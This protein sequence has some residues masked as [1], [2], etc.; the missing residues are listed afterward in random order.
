MNCFLGGLKVLYF[1]KEFKVVKS[2]FINIGGNGIEI[3]GVK[4]SVIFE[5]IIFVN[6]ENG[7]M[8]IDIDVKNFE[9]FFDG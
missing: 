6:N 4:S 2:F 9:G 7:V 8:F 3:V 5:N 1:E